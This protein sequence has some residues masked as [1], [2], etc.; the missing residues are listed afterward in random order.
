M[1]RM[2]TT[3][4]PGCNVCTLKHQKHQS[5]SSTYLVCVLVSTDD[6]SRL[7]VTVDRLLSPP[8]STPPAHSSSR[9]AAAAQ[10]QK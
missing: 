2:S 10:Q 9:M 5:S 1:V 7:F 4:I 8:S 3:P 6:G